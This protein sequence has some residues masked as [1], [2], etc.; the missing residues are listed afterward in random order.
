MNGFRKDSRILKTSNTSKQSKAMAMHLAMINTTLLSID[1]LAFVT[2][3]LADTQSPSSII[4]R[5]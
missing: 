4:E 5:L 3:I 2:A 1:N